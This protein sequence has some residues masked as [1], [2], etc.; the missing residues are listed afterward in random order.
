MITKTKVIRK[1]VCCEKKRYQLT[2]SIVS[3]DNCSYGIEV[4]CR[5][6]NV[7][8]TERIR[9]GESYRYALWL[10]RLFAKETV[11]PIA[12]KETFENL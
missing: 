8:E 1:I 2:Y 11:F 5:S 9:V 7:T 6:Q 12:L 3:K 10:L 4:T